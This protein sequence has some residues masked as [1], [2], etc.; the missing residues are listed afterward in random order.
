MLTLYTKVSIPENVLFHEV[1]DEFVDEMVLLNLTS[2]KYFSLDDVG[3][4]MWQLLGEGGEL[5]AVHQAL[6]E[7]YTV[8]PQQLE[9]DLL[10]LADRLVANG[11]LQIN[12]E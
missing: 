11:L 4:R 8:E 1:S 3:T 6:L 9:K 2:G 5:K 10:E 7:E 12:A